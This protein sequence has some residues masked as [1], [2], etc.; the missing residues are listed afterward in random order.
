MCRWRKEVCRGIDDGGIGEGIL[1]SK[2]KIA[3]LNSTKKSATKVIFG[4]Y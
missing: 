3:F 1:K 4:N 2:P